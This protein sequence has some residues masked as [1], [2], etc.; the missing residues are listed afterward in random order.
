MATEIRPLRAA[1]GG[2]GDQLDGREPAPLCP[3]LHPRCR[4]GG[5]GAASW[6]MGPAVPVDGGA[7]YPS[8]PG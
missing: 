5:D 1:R 3:P 7:L 4:L 8:I 2:R 6:Q